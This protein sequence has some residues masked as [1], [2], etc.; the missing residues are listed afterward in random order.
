M[1]LERIKKQAQ[2]KLKN[3]L[4]DKIRAREDER[5]SYQEKHKIASRDT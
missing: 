4:C 2:L 5:H 3:K 1:E